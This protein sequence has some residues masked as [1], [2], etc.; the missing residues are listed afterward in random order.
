M[1]LS[2]A[3]TIGQNATSPNIVVA[4]DQSTGADAT[5]SQRR[6]YV[7]NSQGTYLVPSGTTTDYTQWAYADASISLN[8]LT[9][10]EAV[11]VRVDWLNSSNVVLYTLTQQYCLAQYSKNF[12]YYLV[13]LTG[14]TPSIPADTNYD[15]N[16]AIFWATLR[17]AINAVEVAD[18]LSGSQNCLNRCTE[19]RL[20]QSYYF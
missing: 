18:D 11:S 3:F 10:D 19:M 13:Q 1:P 9:Q 4:V 8:I 7:Q 16:T 15:S 20:N 14:V 12:L 6:I 5:I 2:A 17:G